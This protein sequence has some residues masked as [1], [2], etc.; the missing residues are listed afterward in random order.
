MQDLDGDVAIVLEIV[1]EI[2]GGHATLA[3]FAV[4]AVAVDEGD[5]EAIGHGGHGV[6]NPSRDA[7]SRRRS[8]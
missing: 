1:R 8:S 4:E 5:R 7:A 2:H 6:V 3:E